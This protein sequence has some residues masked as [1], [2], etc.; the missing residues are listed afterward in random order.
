MKI[1]VDAIPRA[2]R[3]VTFGIETPWAV[4]ATRLAVDGEVRELSGRAV[5]EARGTEVLVHVEHQVVAECACDRCGESVSLGL[6]ASADLSFFPQTSVGTA[7][8]ELLEGDLDVGW[9][10]GGEVSLSDVL[11][12]A[13]ALSMPSRVVCEDILGCESRTVALLA[14]QPS[15]NDTHPFAG[16]KDL[17]S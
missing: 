12:E 14:A 2:G 17:L 16:L 1:A 10:E 3:T 8:V 15:A 4:E 5:L 13:I 6:Q 7:E 9:Y 11:S